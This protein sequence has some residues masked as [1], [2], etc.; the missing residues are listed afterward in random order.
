[1]F[2]LARRWQVQ[3]EGGICSAQLFGRLGMGSVVDHVVH[4]AQVVISNCFLAI[5]R[6]KHPCRIWGLAIL[7]EHGRLNI[8]VEPGRL[9]ILVEPGEL[10]IFAQSEGLTI[11]VASG[12]LIGNF[13][14][15]YPLFFSDTSSVSNQLYI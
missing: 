8:L 1:M 2:S 13:S 4:N 14:Q 5:S 12:G 11:P 15:N 10:N 6:P 7:V 9:A 3:G